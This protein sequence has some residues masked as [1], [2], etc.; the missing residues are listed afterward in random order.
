MGVDW[1]RVTLANDD[2]DRLIKALTRED[3]LRKLAYDFVQNANPHSPTANKW[4]PLFQEALGQ[5]ISAEQAI[6]ELRELALNSSLSDGYLAERAEKILAR[7]N[8]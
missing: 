8:V 1:T 7:A 6:Q 5:R 2:Y 4:R 3:R